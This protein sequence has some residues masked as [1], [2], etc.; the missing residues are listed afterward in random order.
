MKLSTT[1]FTFAFTFAA[2]LSFASEGTITD[3][4]A[5]DEKLTVIDED[6]IV[7]EV[8]NKE[9]QFDVSVGDV[10][11]FKSQNQNGVT[12]KVITGVVNDFSIPKH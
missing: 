11:E 1:L 2:F 9:K 4:A 8:S 12:S 5:Q 3:V 6:G 7:Q 10:I